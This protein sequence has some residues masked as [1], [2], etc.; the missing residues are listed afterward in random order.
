MNCR[1][2]DG[3]AGAFVHASTVE[4]WG[5]VVNEA[6]ASGL[7]VLVSNRCGCAADLVQE[8]HNGFCFDPLNVEA[9]A[10]MMLKVSASGFPLSDFGLAGREQIAHWGPDRFARSMEAACVR[11]LATQRPKPGLLARGITY[12]LIRL[13]ES[14]FTMSDC[15]LASSNLRA[16]ETDINL[17]STALR[18]A[19][20]R[21]MSVTTETELNAQWID[22]SESRGWVGTRR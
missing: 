12:A 21:E 15:F 4:P 6:M 17:T 5:L 7:P 20:N 3:L 19:Q 18:R 16:T 13:L 11:A 2:T 8:G 9:L 10:Q 1:C 14:K 22:M